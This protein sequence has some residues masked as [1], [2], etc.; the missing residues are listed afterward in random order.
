MIIKAAR[1][2]KDNSIPNLCL[3]YGSEDYLKIQFKNNLLNA[4][5]PGKDSMNYSSFINKSKKVDESR[6]FVSELISI[7]NTAPF[8]SDKRVIYCENTG[9]FKNKFE[10][11]ADLLKNLPD[12]TYMVFMESEVAKNTTTYKTVNSKG[13]VEEYKMPEISDLKAWTRGRITK[14]NLKIDNNALH[15]FVAATSLNMSYM[16]NELDKLITYCLNKENI[17]LEDVNKICIQNYEE[18]IFNI[19]NAIAKKNK[20]LAM[21][22]Y[23]VLYKLNTNP[24][25]ILY[26]LTKRF[27]LILNISLALK[28]NMNLDDIASGLGVYNEYALEK[29]IDAAKIFSTNSLYKILELSKDYTVKLNTGLLS[30]QT[31]IEMFI[32][33]CLEA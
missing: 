5:M 27:S 24:R 16:S 4:L 10:E 22:E 15:E 28:S 11:I 19:I 20:P 1:I 14:A 26:L 21:K 8:F 33:K 32:I 9:F 17:T 23:A 25:N 3:L 7:A 29:N 30:E 18:Q 13:F 12:F 31:G 6:G 2:I